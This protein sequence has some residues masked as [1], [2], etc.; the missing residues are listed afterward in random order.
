MH[1]LK[2]LENEVPIAFIII[3]QYFYCRLEYYVFHAIISD[4]NK[5]FIFVV[6]SLQLE[7]EQ[8]L[9]PI[10]KYIIYIGIL[11]VPV[12]RNVYNTNNS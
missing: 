3:I 8:C 6:T 12:H 1:I 4:G 11:I 7:A 9:E 2:I 5:L 10:H